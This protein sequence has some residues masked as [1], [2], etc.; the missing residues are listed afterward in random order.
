MKGNLSEADGP[1]REYAGHT[2][3]SRLDDFQ[4]DKE[5]LHC[6][7]N[8]HAMATCF[9]LHGYPDWYEN[10]KAQKA[11]IFKLSNAA[12]ITYDTPLDA[13]EHI[14]PRHEN[15]QLENIDWTEVMQKEVA[16]YLKEKIPF[17]H[18]NFAQTEYADMPS[19]ISLTSHATTTLGRGVWIIDTSVSNLMCN[20]FNLLDQP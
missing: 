5:S 9:Q 7:M 13:E 15:N 2:N 12:N 1:R 11:Q 16:K 14:E 3:F 17:S 18:V 4:R 8:G 6:D 20:T 10:I 19:H